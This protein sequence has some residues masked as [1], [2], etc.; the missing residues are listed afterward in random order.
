LIGDALKKGDD[1]GEVAIFISFKCSKSSDSL[2]DRTYLELCSIETV[3]DHM[4][5]DQETKRHITCK[6]LD[7]HRKSIEAIAG[8]RRI[9]EV[10]NNCNCALRVRMHVSQDLLRNMSSGTGQK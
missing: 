10:W 3:S 9:A 4:N 5:N 6:W 1:G 8:K 7:K 2:N